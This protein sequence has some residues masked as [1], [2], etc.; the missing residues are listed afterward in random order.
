MVGRAEDA[1]VNEAFN[2]LP[3]RP[4]TR[5]CVA[6]VAVRVAVR[7]LRLPLPGRV[8]VPE[9]RRGR[10]DTATEA[11]IR[12]VRPRLHDSEVLQLMHRLL[13]PPR[14]AKLDVAV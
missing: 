10:H 7:C 9:R 5:P 4:R 8:R 11:K 14:I 2:L 6:G 13:R 3:E 12:D 1:E